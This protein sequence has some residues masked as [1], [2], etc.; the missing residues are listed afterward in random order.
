VTELTRGAADAAGSPQSS[1]LP[2]VAIICGGGKFPLA[3][4]GA[5]QRS[6]RDI[7]LIGLI[8][9][10]DA[11]VADFPHL[12][13][14]IGE[15]GKLFQTLKARAI[16]DVALIGTIARPQL[17]SEI[18]PDFGAL[19]RLPEIARIL[20]GGDNHALTNILRLF[21]REG[22]RVLGAEQLAPE[23]LAPDGQMTPLSPSKRALAELDFGRACLAALSSFDVGQALVV[24]RRRILAIEAAEGT[25]GMLQ[26]VAELRASGRLRAKGR[27]GL[28]I[29][30]PKKGQDLRVDLPAIGPD[31]IAAAERAM[32]AG[33]AVES[34]GV[35]MLERSEI[36]ARA[37]AA[38]LF[39]I[40]FEKR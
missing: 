18:R 37:V 5:A 36:I 9:A 2:P 35:L 22:L 24:G 33:I 30:A 34:H 19:T 15:L 21:E 12:W 25:D 8:G 6:G 23:L 14:R 11:A 7:L 13:L 40:G 1:S 20:I 10:A 39:L 31:T 16:V 27:F 32:L 38:G 3:V 17:L 4:A 28:L 29:K 26:R